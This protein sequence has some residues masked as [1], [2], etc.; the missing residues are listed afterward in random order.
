MKQVGLGGATTFDVQVPSPQLVKKPVRYMSPEWQEVFRKAALK[1]ASLNLELAIATSAGWSETGGKWVEPADASK[2]IVWSEK[3]MEGSRLVQTELPKPPTTNGPYQDFPVQLGLAAISGIAPPKFDEYFKDIAV[4]ALKVARAQPLPIPTMDVDGKRYSSE[5]NAAGRLKEGVHLRDASQ[6]P[7]T[8]TLDYGTA[9]SV[10]SA[11]I[12]IAD[13]IN[14]DGAVWEAEIQASND[15]SSWHSVC[16]AKLSELPVTI[17]FPEQK[18]RYFRI[19]VTAKLPN[20]SA[21]RASSTTFPGVDIDSQLKYLGITDSVPMLATLRFSGDAKVNRFEQKAGYPMAH[22]YYALDQDADY[23]APATPL[24]DVI[25][26]TSKMNFDG[27]LEWNA[28]AGQW[29]ILRIGYSLTGKMNHPA[30]SESTGFE[31]DKYDGNAVRRYLEHYLGVYKNAVQTDDFAKSGLKALTTDSIE[32]GTA[33]WTPELV[34]KFR[35]L[36]G[37]D[38]TPWMPALTGSIIESRIKTDAFLYDYRKTLSDLIATEHYK[39]IADVARE[40]GLS[41]YGESLE[42]SR[43]VLGDDMDMRRYATVPM[44]AIWA[45]PPGEEP[46]SSAQADIRG[47]ASV[48]H[49]YGQN[50]VAAESFTSMLAPWAFAPADLRHTADFAFTQG[51]NRPVIHASAH[52]PRDDMKPGISLSIFG[53]T[54]NRHESWAALAKPWIDYLTRSSLLLQQGRFYADVAYFYGEESSVVTQAGDGYFPDAPKRYG[55]DFVNATALTDAFKVQKGKFEATSGMQYQV[56]YLGGTSKQMTL[57]VL[58]RIADL[59]EQGG[60]VVGKAPTGSPS[61]ADD[62]AAYTALVNRLWSGKEETILGKGRVIATRDV[63]AALAELQIAPDFDYR[64]KEGT[65]ELLYTHRKVEDGEIYF[66]SNRETHDVTAT[67]DFRVTGKAPEIW[68]AE[69]ASIEPVGFTSEG[70]ITSLD[71]QLKANESYFVVFR[72]DTLEKSVSI[73][74]AISTVSQTI[75]GP[76]DVSF[77]QGRGAP[78]SIELKNLISLPDH[79][80]SAIKYFSGIVSYKTSFTL[81]SLSNTNGMVLDLGAVGDIA[82]VQVNGKVIG[83]AWHAPYQVR[84]GSSLRA[85]KNDLEIRVANLWVNRLIGDAQVGKNSR[86]AKTTIPT[87]LKE[88][89]LRP[90]GLI[91]PLRLINL[92]K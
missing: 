69:D 61:L 8:I 18:A 27:R 92:Q 88:A 3:I 43:P 60:I 84:L 66:V 42:F 45:A 19:V 25:D 79:A 11:T 72:K 49:I 74:P 39:T 30:T 14:E 78:K 7:I 55:Y 20:A 2:K 91:G 35:A 47:A 5:L 6:K 24:A 4:Y 85:G 23:N 10:R 32:S 46:T 87:Y 12:H 62:P 86:I 37:Y 41:V 70:S 76:W 28:P 29:K 58:K 53:Q 13:V 48:A 59:V 34:T 21:F 67:V 80:K 54:F 77:E 71:L 16:S 57:P 63:E 56:L 22:D 38:P 82:E 64:V 52:V 81:D 65:A 17:S 31:V 50:L 9:Q 33:N 44:A 1:A 40:N 75:T 15:E 83:A 36:R 51:V 73:V 26:L 90:A 89:P 68:R